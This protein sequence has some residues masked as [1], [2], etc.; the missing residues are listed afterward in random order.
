MINDANWPWGFYGLTAT[1]SGTFFA[2]GIPPTVLMVAGA[3]SQYWPSE[4]AEA[5][6][7]GNLDGRAV[8]L[9]ECGHAVNFDRPAEFNALLLRFPREL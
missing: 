9:E 1:N 8:V 3:D 7:R 6:V 4:H 2:D 5:A